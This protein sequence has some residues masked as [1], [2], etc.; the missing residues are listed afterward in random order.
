MERQEDELLELLDDDEERVSRTSNWD[1]FG[2]S[3]AE[4]IREHVEK[5]IAEV[6]TVMHEVIG[7]EMHLDLFFVPPQKSRDYVTVVTS[8]ISDRPMRVPQGKE[9]FR[10]AEL[11]MR[12]PPTWPLSR[13]AMEDGRY[14]WPVRCLTALAESAGNSDVFLSS[15]QVVPNGNPPRAYHESTGFCGA[16]LTTP[17]QDDS[18]FARMAV[19]RGSVVH[20]YE[21]LP[22]YAEELLYELRRGPEVLEQR[23]LGEAKVHVVRP[24]RGNVAPV[25]RPFYF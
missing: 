20:F 1:L 8:G 15:G 5:H 17:K 25:R 12:L 10:Y 22:V 9:D 23:L 6:Q 18:H 2:E 14:G 13:D 24:D 16:F 7:D 11:L 3:F 4:Q 21:V 19:G